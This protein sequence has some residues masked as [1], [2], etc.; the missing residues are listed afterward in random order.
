MLEGSGSTLAPR[1]SGRASAILPDRAW[2]VAISS[3]KKAP[4]EAKMESA[5]SHVN[6]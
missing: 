6:S 5:Q 2:L 4:N 1:R 3:S